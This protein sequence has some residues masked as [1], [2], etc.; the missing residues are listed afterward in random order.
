MQATNQEQILQRYRY[1]RS[2]LLISMIIGYAAFYLT[3][4]SFNFVMPVMQLELGLDKGDIGWITSLFYLAYGSSK[5]V[6]G[7][8]H[9]LTGYRWFMGAGLVM[10]GVLN[11]MFAF[12]SSFSALLIIWTL[13]GF[14]QGWGWPPCAR[15]LTHWYSRNERGFWWGCWNISINIVG[16]TIPMLSAFLATT[17]SWQAVLMMPGIIGILLGIWLCY[18]LCGI[19]QQQ[20]LPSIGHWRQDLL[21]LRHEQLS[22][23]MP[24]MQI[25]RDT[26]LTNKTIWLLGLSYLL[27]YLIRMA[28]NDWGNLWLSEIH[29]TNLLSANATLSLFELGGLAGALLSGWGSDLLFRGQRA[30]MILLFALGLFIS[31]TALWLTPIHHYALLA[32]CF[33]SIGF[34]VFGPQMLIGLAATEYCHKQAAGTVTGYLGLYAYLGAAMAGWPMSQVIA[35]YGWSGIF[36]LLTVAA[37]MMGLLLMPLLMADV[38]KRE[39]MAG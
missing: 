29:G 35:H 33:F 24:M 13:N 14:F 34:F 23:P 9:D 16:I 10:T 39:H 28:I 22:P 17:Y 30:P 36:A 4:K 1:W 11:I 12:C 3:R 7:I 31:V 32:A 38:S 19:P 20:G 6:S 27:V 37:A 15:L 18:Q 2:R 25:L 5:F 8:F 26:I 21:E